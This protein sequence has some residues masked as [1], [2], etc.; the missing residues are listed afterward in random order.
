MLD[1]TAPSA[2]PLL[3]T[4]EQLC[5]YVGMSPATLAR[6]CPVPPLDIGAKML[7]YSR[8][9][10]DAWVG[11][12][13][14]QMPRPRHDEPSGAAGVETAAPAIPVNRAREA[15]ERARARASK[16]ARKCRSKHRNP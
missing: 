6:V 1:S 5:A 4:R 16:E 13:Q 15:I 3:L 11:S 8:P 14:P 7:R 2:W 9:Q 10:I 12:L